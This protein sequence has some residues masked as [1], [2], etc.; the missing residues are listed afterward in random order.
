MMT[1]NQ[2]CGVAKWGAAVDDTPVPMPQSVV[3]VVVLRAQAGI[4]DEF[5]LVRDH[6]SPNDTVFRDDE[7]IDLSE[8]NV[9]YSLRRCEVSPRDA[10]KSAP[11]LAVFVDDRMEVVTRPKQTG[12][13]ILQLFGFPL[14]IKLYRDF[15]SPEDSM[16]PLER[17]VLFREGPVFYSRQGGGGLKVIIN[18]RPFTEE[19]GVKEEMTGLEIASLVYPE[20][21]ENTRIW[22]LEGEKRPVD[23]SET[24][25]I[26]NC[27][28]FEVVRKDV[29][30]GFELTRLQREIAVLAQGEAKVSLVESPSAVVYH[31]L[32]VMSGLPVEETDVLVLIPGGYPGQMLDGAFLPVDSPLLGCVKG[33]PQDQIVEAVGQRWK[34]VSYHPHT[35]GI[36]PAWDPTRHGIHTY[37]G[38][39]LSWL[40]DAK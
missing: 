14:N 30:G 5:V 19:D 39:I 37:L 7:T 38:E 18:A 16:I 20:N 34:L 33:S 6:N 28:K 8:G 13:S 15:E 25:E 31:D 26:K 1:T 29:T 32:S 36:G 40:H 11:K 27:T 3:P 35:N 4:D 22:S 10:C 21:P 24:I 17:E 9:F 2:I 23:H 12:K